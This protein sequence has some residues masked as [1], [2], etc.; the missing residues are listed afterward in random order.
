M[1]QKNKND[2]YLMLSKTILGV[3]LNIKG[4][5]KKEDDICNSCMFAEHFG[6]SIHKTRA[7][8]NI[9]LNVNSYIFIILRLILEVVAYKCLNCVTAYN[10]AYGLIIISNT[11][12]IHIFNKS[13]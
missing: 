7:S 11:F 12:Y 3:V 13:N 5:S 4:S 8:S 2:V 10:P 1:E 9:L 6:C